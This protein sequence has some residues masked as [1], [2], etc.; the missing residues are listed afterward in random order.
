MVLL[1]FILITQEKYSVLEE[2]LNHCKE[3]LDLLNR[4]LQKK[5][6]CFKLVINSIT[7]CI[8]LTRIVIC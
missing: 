5:D 1:K 8:L 6:V 7:L 4:S 2:E 3:R